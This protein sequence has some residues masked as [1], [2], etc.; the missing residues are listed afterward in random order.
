MNKDRDKDKRDN[1][2]RE[3][4]QKPAMTRLQRL[5]LNVKIVL[6][7]VVLILLG[8]FAA[9]MLATSLDD[10]LGSSGDASSAAVTTVYE[11]GGSP[12]GESLSD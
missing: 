12:S 8:F 7:I 10:V 5:S 4:S 9:Y 11:F 6:L 1:I 3:K 2:R